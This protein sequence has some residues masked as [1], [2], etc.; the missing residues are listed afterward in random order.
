MRAYGNNREDCKMDQKRRYANCAP[1]AGDLREERAA[2]RKTR[3]EGEAE[4]R[5]AVA[6]MAA[7]EDD[8]PG[9]DIM[10]CGPDCPVCNGE[11]ETA[12]DVFERTRGMRR[13][14]NVAVMGWS[15]S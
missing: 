7:A 10:R 15:P 6:C 5:E 9:D 12:E 3:T 13:A 14:A 1:R 8:T 2:K 4:I 11:P